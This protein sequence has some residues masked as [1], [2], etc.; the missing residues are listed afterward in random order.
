MALG[1]FRGSASPLSPNL[2]RN[3][4]ARCCLLTSRQDPRSSLW[5]TYFEPE[6]GLKWSDGDGRWPNGAWLG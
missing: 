2:K 1:V 4:E 3:L 6:P 5:V